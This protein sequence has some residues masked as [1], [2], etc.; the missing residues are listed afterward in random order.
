MKRT[1]I[2]IVVLIFFTVSYAKSASWISYGEKENSSTVSLGMRGNQFGIELGYWLNNDFTV[3]DVFD[4][5]IP[6]SSYESLGKKRVGNTYGIDF[7][8]FKDVIERISV[9]GGLGLYFCDVREIAK[10]T[11]TGLLYSQDEDFETYFA[12]SA[13]LQYSVYKKLML[14]FEYHTVRGI[15]F[16]LGFTY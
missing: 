9:F 6:H 2:S 13:G 5:E 11:A 16:Q 10:S 7:H 12:F 15:G 8:L 1:S 4:Y 14:G 3:D